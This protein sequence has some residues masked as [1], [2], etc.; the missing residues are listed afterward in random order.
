[1]VPRPAR[2]CPTGNDKQGARHAEQVAHSLAGIAQEIR[3]INLPGL[4]AGEDAYDWIGRGGTREQLDELGEAAST[5]QATQEPGRSE[6][7]DR[8]GEG[9]EADDDIGD[10]DK[11]SA[12]DDEQIKADRKVVKSALDAAIDDMNLKYCVVNDGGSVLIF[13]DRFDEALERRVYDR[14]RQGSLMLLH[15]NEK[16]CTSV[17][18]EGK[19]TYKPLASVWLSNKRRRDYKKGVVF[20]PTTT[21]SRNGK[22]NLWRS[23]GYEPK[24]GRWGLMK[25][26]LRTIVCGGEETYFDYLMGWMACAVQHPADQGEVA[27]VLRGG[28]G[29][30]K[31]ILG[32]ALRK[33]FGQHGMY[34]SQSKHLVGAFNAHLR[35][36]VLLF[37][38]EA[39]FAG[40]KP[41]EGTL[42]ALITEETLTIES[43]GQNV[44]L[45]KNHLHTIMA[46]NEKR[47]IP[48]SLDERRFFV[49]DVSG[50]KQGD[51]P[52]FKAIIKELE[53]GGYAAM[54]H[55]LL[56]HDI[57]SFDVRHIP[58]TAALDDQ[59]KLTMPSEIQWWHGVLLRGYVYR[60]KYG[61]ENHF[62]QWHD[63]MSTDVLYDAYM[64][65]AKSRNDRYRMAPVSFGKFMNGLGCKPVRSGGADVIG[66]HQVRS[67]Y[68]GILR[69]ELIKKDRPRGYR[70]GTLEQARTEFE[71][72]TGLSF[73]W[74]PEEEQTDEDPS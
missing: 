54:L 27:V 30:G 49:L 42:K 70:I 41:A 52:Y 39:F 61:L 22:L 14:M 7:E 12:A 73:T 25:E 37:A 32:H 28:K 71:N 23:F 44:I 63:F 31:G 68:D 10:D 8:S 24:R 43:K 6:A 66:E 53:S 9:R 3:I 21:E 1:M 55:D 64:D 15:A 74:E 38:D 58:A 35:D 69:A 34:I 60:S 36:C 57:S 46:S 50:A 48:A 5:F 18:P 26:H 2:L 17:S 56:K 20:D 16:I 51:L 33:I 59:K 62:G 72:Y 65:H 67:D 4:A 47:V 19:R 13:M 40:D 11:A 45:S 29:V